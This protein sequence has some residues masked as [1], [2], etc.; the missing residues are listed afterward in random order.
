MP[1]PPE[2]VTRIVTHTYLDP[3]SGNP[4]AGTVTFRPSSVMMYP[5]GTII[6]SNIIGILNPATGS[7]SVEVPVNDAPGVS[8]LNSWYTLTEAVVEDGDLHWVRSNQNVRVP[9]GV[10]SIDIGS[11]I[12]VPEEDPGSTPIIQGPPGPPGSTLVWDQSTPSPTWT[13]PHSLGILA[14][15]VTILLNGSSSPVIT[16]TTYN[17]NQVVLEF[18]TAVAGKAYLS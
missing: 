16:D 13:I 3:D 1:F 11:L 15:V 5:G 14:P 10:G 12:P 9:T 18:P 4:C 7:V 17:I 6:K 8:P 2:V